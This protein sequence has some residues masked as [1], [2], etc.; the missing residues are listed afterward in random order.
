[1]AAISENTRSRCQSR[2]RCA[3]LGLVTTAPS[4]LAPRV[5]A[6]GRSRILS[7]L[8]REGLERLAARAADLTL[9]PG[10][11]LFTRG[12]AGDALFVLLEGEMEISVASSGGRTVRLASLAAGSVI[13]EMAVLDGG[14]RS[15]DASAVRRCRLCKFSRDAV[16]DALIAEP[17][18]M[19]ALLADLSARLRQ[20]NSALENAVVLD[21]KGKLANLLL[22]ESGGGQRLVQITQTEMARRLSVSREKLNRRLHAWKDEGVLELS[23]VGVRILDADR[24]SNATHPDDE[25]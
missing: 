25:G 16:M 12:D 19:A 13:G 23:R 6:L 7:Q 11:R 22:Q 2:K 9:E 10:A 1:M 15:A 24:L 18:A 8:S 4:P 21:L 5:S 20:A 17:K 14:P 3:K